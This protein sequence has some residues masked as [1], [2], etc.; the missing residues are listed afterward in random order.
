M[1]SYCPAEQKQA[2]SKNLYMIFFWWW[3]HYLH[4]PPTPLWHSPPLPPPRWRH[5]GIAPNINRFLSY[6]DKITS[7]YLGKPSHVIINYSYFICPFE[8]GKYG[9]EGEKN[10]KISISEKI[11]NKKAFFIVFKWLSFGEKIKNSGHKI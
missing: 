7:A 5:F 10:T 1:L 6:F 3:C 4:V 11:G 2:K 8:L 9:K